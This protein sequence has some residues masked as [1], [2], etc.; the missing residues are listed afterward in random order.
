MRRRV[1]VNQVIGVAGSVFSLKALAFA[2]ES[3]VSLTPYVSRCTAGILSE[4]FDDVAAFQQQSEWCWAASI[5]MVFGYYKHRISQKRI[6][7][8][9]WGSV[10]NMPGQP[11]QILANLN[12]NWKD[13]DGK[14]FSSSGDILTANAYTA[15][16]DLKADRPL[17]IGA[18]GHATVFNCAYF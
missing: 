5:E 1:F 18:L 7:K 4:D 12:R 9:T 15:V 13:D 17:I 14:S 8:E 16:I 2:E 11:A 6:V 3:C 10:V